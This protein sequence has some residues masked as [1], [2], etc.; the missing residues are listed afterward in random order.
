MIGDNMKKNAVQKQLVCTECNYK[1]YIFR[2]AGKNKPGGHI[3]H[4]YC[5]VC[6]DIRPF[7]EMGKLTNPTLLMAY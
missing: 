4:M 3:K 2:Q 5:P 1:L 6:R 7:E